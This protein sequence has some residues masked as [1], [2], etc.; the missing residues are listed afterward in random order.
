MSNL[1]ALFHCKSALTEGNRAT[2]RMPI[3]NISSVLHKSCPEIADIAFRPTT[4]DLAHSYTRTG[5]QE[6]ATTTILQRWDGFMLQSL[7]NLKSLSI[8]GLSQ[9]GIREL[10]KLLVHSKR[11]QRLS[12]DSQFVDDSLL[13]QAASLK[14]LRSLL[15]K[16]SGTKV[17]LPSLLY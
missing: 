12:V 6:G 17:G 5:T 16:S 11:L 9:E 15:I 2:N 13:F 8:S 10:E 14:Q 1:L 3:R 4:S 7:S